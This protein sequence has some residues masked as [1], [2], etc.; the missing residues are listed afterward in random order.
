MMHSHPIQAKEK[1]RRN[2]THIFFPFFSS[3][4]TSDAFSLFKHGHIYTRK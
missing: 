4:S 3:L 1:R 2:K